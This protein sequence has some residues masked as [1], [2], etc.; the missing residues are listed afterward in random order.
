MTN[1]ERLLNFIDDFAKMELPDIK[2]SYAHRPSYTH[3]ILK[4]VT[5]SVCNELV[6]Y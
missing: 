5:S 4:L 1:C 6:R 2:A 3:G